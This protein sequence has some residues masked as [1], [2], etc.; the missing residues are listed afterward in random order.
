M[1]WEQVNRW[2][3]LASKIGAV[4]C[5]IALLVVVDGLLRN[6]REPSNLIKVL[7]GVTV[8]IDGKLTDEVHRLENLTFTSDSDQLKLTFAAIH[9]GYYLGGAMWRGRLA[10]GSRIAPGEYR[11]SVIPK[12]SASASQVPA[13]RIVVFPD[14]LSL[15]KSSRSL[16]RRWL[17]ISPFKIAAGCLPV[18]LLAFGTVYLLSGKRETLL[19]AAGQA[20]VY[21][22]IRTDNDYEIRFG[23]GAAQGIG[24]GTQV[25]ISDDAGAQVATGIVEVSNQTDAAAQVTTSQEIKVGYLVSRA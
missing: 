11:L 13:Y 6:F 1:N 23:L 12:H 10:V 20:E 8:A 7:P 4:F 16:V 19:A 5:L 24:P 9:P 2:R 25:I 14:D 22:V 18:I 15:Q 3:D 17:W 21:R